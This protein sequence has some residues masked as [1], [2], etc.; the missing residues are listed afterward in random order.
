MDR[1]YKK[2]FNSKIYRI[3]DRLKKEFIPI[4]AYKKISIQESIDLLNRTFHTEH[5]KFRISRA[6]LRQRG[7]KI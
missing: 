2:V 6:T 5:K 3:W 7:L 4:S 1:R